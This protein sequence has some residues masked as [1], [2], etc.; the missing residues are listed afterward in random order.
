[1][2]IIYNELSLAKAILETEKTAL[3]K[4][5]TLTLETDFHELTRI[6]PML[7][8]RSELTPIFNPDMSIISE[9]NGFWI[10]GVNAEG[11]IVHLQAVRMQRL[12]QFTLSQH[13]YQNRHL[14]C[15]PNKGFD[16]DLSLFDDVPAAHNITGTVCY[17]GE[18]WMSPKSGGMQGKGIASPLAQMA[19]AI[20]MM[21]WAPDFMFCLSVPRVMRTGFS[22]RNGYLHMHPKGIQW[23]Q[24]ITKDTVNDSINNHKKAF[25]EKGNIVYF[26]EWLSWIDNQ[27][28]N[29]T[30]AISNAQY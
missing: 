18:L 2:T 20:S 5:I 9:K 14:Y 11:E 4:G 25:N 13:L 28:L 12:E 26:N 24:V 21:K 16:P 10:K 6:S 15:T 27:E 29:Q 22:V 7:P 17:H 3:L 19:M 30:L 8:N 23:R 1:M